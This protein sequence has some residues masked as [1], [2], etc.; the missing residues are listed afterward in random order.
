VF[1]LTFKLLS[2]LVTTELPE[3]PIALWN[4]QWRRDLSPVLDELG[5]SVDHV[6][7][8]S[9]GGAENIRNFATICARCNARKSAKSKEDYLKESKPWPV[10]GRHGEPKDWDGLASLFVVLARKTDRDLTSTEKGWLREFEARYRKS[11]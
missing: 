6:H 11:V 9:K 1:P 10:K 5:V 4:P 3:V 7:A 8:F 2:E